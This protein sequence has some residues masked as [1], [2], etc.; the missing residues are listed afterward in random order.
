MK[1]SKDD[2]WF[3][4][5]EKKD[6]GNQRGEINERKSQRCLWEEIRVM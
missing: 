6:V 3:R 5:R 2:Q 1:R 4:R